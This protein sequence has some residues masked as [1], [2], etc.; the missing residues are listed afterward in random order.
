MTYDYFRSNSLASETP[1]NFRIV[2]IILPDDLSNQDFQD[3]L[4]RS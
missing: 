4:I 2:V 3:C 1:Y